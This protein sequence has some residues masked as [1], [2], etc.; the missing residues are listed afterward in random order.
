MGRILAGDD[1]EVVRRE[2]VAF[3]DQ[4]FDLVEHGVGEFPGEA[5]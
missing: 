2:Q 3:I 4:A 1:V 5:S